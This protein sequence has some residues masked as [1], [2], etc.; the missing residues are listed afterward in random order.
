MTWVRYTLPAAA[1]VSAASP[2]YA[3]QYLSIEEAQKQAFPS[4]TNFTEVQAGRVW[5]AEAG[6]KVAGFFVFDRVIGKH[7]FIDY[8]VALTPGGAVHKVEILQYRESYG[9][10]I[11]SPSWLAQFVG[12]TGGSALKINGDIRNISGAT[13]SSTHVTEGVKRILAAYANRLR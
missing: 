2:A 1:I 7:L 4:A 11:R 9:G 10:E 3:V 12:K 6:G 5:K 8:A 13:L